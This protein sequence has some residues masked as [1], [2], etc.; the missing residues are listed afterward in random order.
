MRKLIFLGALVVGCTNNSADSER[1]GASHQRIIDGDETTEFEW[2]VHI[3]SAQMA[4][5]PLGTV[6]PVYTWGRSCTGALISR[7]L[8]LTARHCINTAPPFLMR[9]KVNDSEHQPSVCRVIPIGPGSETP[10]PA[11]DAGNGP[12]HDFYRT[13]SDVAL[14]VL[15]DT[16]FEANSYGQLAAAAATPR[17]FADFVTVGGVRNAPVSNIH[18]VDRHVKRNV[19]A[20]VEPGAVPGAFY[21]SFYFA[22]GAHTDPG[23]SGGPFL[24][25]GLIAGVTT[26]FTNGWDNWS[27]VDTEALR[28]EINGLVASVTG[29]DGTAGVVWP[30]EIRLVAPPPPA[31]PPPAADA[32]PPD[33]APPPADAG[34]IDAAPVE[35]AAP[36]DAH[37]GLANPSLAAMTPA[38]VT[39][40]G[41]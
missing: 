35:P 22:R 13:S 32:G 15:G 18:Y 40:R 3:E 41:T 29:C 37:A 27:R 16:G 11:G 26:G 23:D 17:D 36:T 5:L 33:V 8:V 20:R 28:T 31:P 10:L 19:R 4:P 14:L 24:R 7:T 38:R 30:P 39:P 21:D 34:P 25:G 2:A 9:I 6:T 1:V 12:W